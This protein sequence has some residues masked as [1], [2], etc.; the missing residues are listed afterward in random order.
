MKEDVY[1]IDAK[2]TPVGKYGGSLVRISATELGIIVIKALL[3]N[4]STANKYI[5]EVIMGNALS[6]GLK[7]NPAGG[8][9]NMSLC[10]CLI[11]NYRFGAKI[12]NR[13]IFFDGLFC[14]L[15]N[16]HM[17]MIAKYVAKKISR[18][19]QEKYVLES[20]RKAIDTVNTG[21][22]KEEIVPITVLLGEKGEV[23]KLV[24]FLS[25]DHADYITG[26]AISVN[27]ECIKL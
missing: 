20:H 22:F 3:D 17:G 6:A 26:Q 16:E 10:S 4:N 23:A 21:K 18:K 13:T 11:D 27:E 5:D 1:I 14:S 25:S 24:A 9:E 2:R 8:M 7:Q 15:T 19:E 12:G